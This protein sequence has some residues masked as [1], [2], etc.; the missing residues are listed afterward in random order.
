[1]KHI[2]V[3]NTAFLGDALLTLPLIQSIKKASPDSRIDYYVRGGLSGLFSAHPA[4]DK[5]YEFRKGRDLR[6]LA[7]MRILGCEIKERGY[8][9]WLSPHPSL[10]SAWL[11]KKSGAFSIGYKSP[12]YNR[13]LYTTTVS[14]HFP[15]LHEVERVLQLSG[16]LGLKELS[17]WPELVLPEDIRQKSADFFAGLPAGPVLGMHP[18]SVWGT[19]R[20]PAAYF[21]RIGQLALEMGASVIVFG[22]PGEEETAAEVLVGISDGVSRAAQERVYNMAGKLDLPELAACIAGLSCY[23]GNDS[24]P[25]HMAWCQH[26]PVVALFGAT[27]PSF[28]FSP[29]GEQSVVLDVAGL[30]CRPCS[31][32]GPK[33]CPQKHFRCMM[34]L[35]PELVWPEV[36]KR[37]VKI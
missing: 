36:E 9:L 6:S 20:W 18:G 37:L 14:R 24:G 10:R 27:V 4:V 26:V 3:W 22:G 32:H 28:G 2:A 33:E 8:D 21:A 19:K 17:H 5:V 25:M 7:A 12:W 34:E 31:L 13:L 35:V 23:V 30:T 15:D 16:P 1:M 11:A 29:Q